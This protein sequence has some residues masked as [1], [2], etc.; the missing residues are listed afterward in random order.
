[1][2]TSWFSKSKI[3]SLTILLGVSIALP[4]FKRDTIKIGNNGWYFDLTAADTTA[5]ANAVSVVCASGNVGVCAGETVVATLLTG[6][7]ALGNTGSKSSSTTT[8]TVSDPTTTV[9]TITSETS[10]TTSDSNIISDVI[11]AVEDIPSEISTILSKV[12]IDVLGIYN[13]SSVVSDVES[14]VSDVENSITSLI[15]F[16]TSLGQH[17]AAQFG[18]TNLTQLAELIANAVPGIPTFS[19]LTTLAEEAVGAA[20]QNEGENV[21]SWMTYNIEQ[22]ENGL[23]DIINSLGGVNL[24]EF[25]NEI[26]NFIE[27]NGAWKICV[28]SSSENVTYNAPTIFGEIYLNTYGS[29]D[30]ECQ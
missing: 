21:M 29:V 23:T 10:G 26:T 13:L 18:A 6:I 2:S 1:M 5:W 9:A 30:S 4:L 17:I 3:L 15:H 20:I 27:T 24:T 7:M 12:G 19:N 25:S 8:T 22:A 14:T 16:N 11:T 28:G